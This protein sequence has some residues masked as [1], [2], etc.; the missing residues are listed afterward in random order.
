MDDLKAPLRGSREAE[1]KMLLETFW[2]RMRKKRALIATIKVF[3]KL[4]FPSFKKI[5]CIYLFIYFLAMP[6]A[7]ENSQAR[8]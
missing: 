7:C 8:V 3:L 5:F 2:P 4:F 1:N 6:M